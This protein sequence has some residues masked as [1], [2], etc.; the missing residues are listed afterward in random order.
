[1]HNKKA[2]SKKNLESA[3]KN[4]YLQKLNAMKGYF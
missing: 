2:A 3:R 1:M 4:E